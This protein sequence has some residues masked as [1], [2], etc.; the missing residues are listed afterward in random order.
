MTI[1]QL[2]KSTRSLASWTVGKIRWVKLALIYFC[3]PRGDILR[4]VYCEKGCSQYRTLQYLLYGICS[5]QTSLNG[6]TV[7]SDLKVPGT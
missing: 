4:L 2:S 1:R 3:V 5:D 7:S 6:W